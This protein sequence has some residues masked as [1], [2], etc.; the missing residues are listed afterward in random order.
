MKID[1]DTID[2]LAHL[3]RLE[4]NEKEKVEIKNDLQKMLDFCESLN[5]IDTD[6]LEPLI[7]ISEEVNVLRDD[8][9]NQEITHEE[10]LKNAPAKDSDYFRVPKVIDR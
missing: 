3:A 7:F 2:R 5:R 4:F 9:V 6:G 1:N 8:E 10:A